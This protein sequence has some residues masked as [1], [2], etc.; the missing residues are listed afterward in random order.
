MATPDIRADARQ[1]AR[2]GEPAYYDR[3]P[4]T[5]LVGFAVLMLALAGTFNVIQGILAIGDSRVYVADT[6][7]VFSDLNAWGWIITILGAIQLGAA[8]T[9]LSGSELGRWVGVGAAFVNSIGQLF[10]MPAYPFWS[11]TMFAI[12]LLIIYALVAYGGRRLR[13]Q[14]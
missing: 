3:T 4:G 12:D 14:A 1:A 8:L 10:F 11:L 5:G 9:I 13:A 2:G 7:F 6:T